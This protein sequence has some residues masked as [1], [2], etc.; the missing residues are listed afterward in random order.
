MV[1]DSIPSPSD[2]A[3]NSLTISFSSE[4]KA[5]IFPLLFSSVPKIFFSLTFG[6]NFAILS[7]SNSGKSSTLAVSRMEDFAAMVP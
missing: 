1:S 4:R 5:A 2:M 6:I 7:A 3:F